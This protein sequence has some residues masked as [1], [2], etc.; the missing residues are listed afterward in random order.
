MVKILHVANF[1]RKAGG[2]YHHSVEYKLTNGL[3]RNGHQTVNVS[4]RDLARMGSFLG[5]RKFG[6]R[7]ANREFLSLC[8]SME[9]EVILLGHADVITA[10][11]LSQ[12]RRSIDSV[13]ILQ[14]NVDALFTPANVERILSKRDQVDA[15]LV[16]TAGP[17]LAALA[18]PGHV[19]GY[20]PNPVDYSIEAGANHLSSA[21]P[22]DLFFTCGDDRLER[23]AAGESMLPSQWLGALSTEI[24]HMRPLVAGMNGAPPLVGAAYARALTSCAV[25]LN[26][27]RR[28]DF[29]LYSSDRMAHFCG[30]GLAVFMDRATGFGDLFGEDELALFSSRDELVDKMRQILRYPKARQ[31][32]AGAGRAR[33]HALFNEQ[34]IA[35]YVLDVAMG[36]L[37]ASDYEWSLLTPPLLG[38]ISGSAD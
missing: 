31:K 17:A 4:D 26:L 24:A 22:Y 7:A 18:A 28:N 37:R 9:P 38:A 23:N 13:R 33:Y 6:V 11:T 1:G 29:Y 8:R 3:I 34:K 15:T 20:L 21:L 19:V 2:A 32:L 27:S 16:S 25:G 5:H 30:N 10:E 35:R 12:V 36:T 14:W